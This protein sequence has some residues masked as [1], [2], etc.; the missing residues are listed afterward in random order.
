MIIEHEEL[1]GMGIAITWYF[2]S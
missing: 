1:A 2:S